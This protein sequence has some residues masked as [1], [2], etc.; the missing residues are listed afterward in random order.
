MVRVGF[1]IGK[2]IGGA[3]LRN[4]VKRVLKEILK[5]A[6]VEIKGSLDFLIIA[7]KETAGA[8]FLELKEHLESN[9]KSILID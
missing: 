8:D 2:K 1:G 4:K 5:R 7:R 9:L 3:V 6:R